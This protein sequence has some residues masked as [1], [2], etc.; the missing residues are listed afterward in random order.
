MDPLQRIKD[1]FKELEDKSL[2][3][4]GVTVGLVNLDNY[5]RWRVSIIGAKD[6]S[7]KSGLFYMEYTFSNDYPEKPPIIRFLNPIYHPNVNSRNDPELGLIQ[8]NVINK[9]WESLNN[10]IELTSK[11]FTFFYFQYPDYAFDI[12][13][14]KEYK[15]NRAL[16]E[17]KVKYFTK[18]YSNPIDSFKNSGIKFW[19]FSFNDNN[20]N[21]EMTR[22]NVDLKSIYND[23]DNNDEFIT[24]Y[25][26]LN[27]VAKEPVQCQLKEIIRNVLQRFLSKFSNKPNDEPLLILHASRVSLD[28]PIGYAFLNNGDNLTVIINYSI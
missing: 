10:I 27:G 7:Y 26:S 25:F 12:E 20:F 18:K 17:A 5:Y 22:T 11:I 8:P 1:D 13:R 15:E 6:S 16:F 2:L 23:Y 19:D 9:W 14:A 24:I 28:I 4:L 21:E 3:N